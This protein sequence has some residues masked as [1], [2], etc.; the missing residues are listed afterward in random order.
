M[1][2]LFGFEDTAFR[3]VRESEA[4]AVRGA[5]SRRLLRQSYP[6]IGEWLNAEGHRTT[7]G[8]T[9][10]PAT[11]ANVLDHPA[12]AGLAEDDNG[13]LVS[14]GGPQIISPED[15]NAIRALR[16]SNDPNRSRVEQREYLLTGNLSEC[17]L[18]TCPL[19][20]SP[21]ASGARGYRCTPST[22]QHPGGCG[23]VRVKADLL[24]AYVAEHVLAELSKPGVHAVV[25]AARA[26]VLAEAEQ[27]RAGIEDDRKRQAELGNEYAR[28]EI[29]KD[30]F[31]TADQALT[32]SIRQALVK[33]RLLE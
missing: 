30:A 11:V 14:T 33:A 29:S 27:L 15:F 4:A 10:R 9:W 17:G 32:R 5:A 28:R 13:E 2:R 18:C 22:R 26:E 6:E 25:E 20:A 8:G 16:P 31:K 23:R 1:P 21:S 7:R 24:E 12:I 19:D 3:K